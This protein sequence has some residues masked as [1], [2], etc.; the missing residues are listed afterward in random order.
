V[1]ST[2]GKRTERF[3]EISEF[4]EVS[5]I[6]K[7]ERSLSNQ[8]RRESRAKNLTLELMIFVRMVA[9]LI[10]V[11]CVLDLDGCSVDLFVLRCS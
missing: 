6:W 3:S 5:Q 4:R 9:V 10:F 2:E 8:E 11:Y 7:G 1:A